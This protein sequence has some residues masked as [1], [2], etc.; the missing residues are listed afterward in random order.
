MQRGLELDAMLTP[1]E[2]MVSSLSASRLSLQN[3]IKEVRKSKEKEARKRVDQATSD[4]RKAVSI[5]STA[6]AAVAA[7]ARADAAAG[8]T[9]NG[10]GRGAQAPSES[11][12][13]FELNMKDEI[14]I[15]V[16]AGCQPLGSQ[17]FRRVESQYGER[18]YIVTG[19]SDMMNC[20]GTVEAAFL[21][22]FLAKCPKDTEGYGKRG[23]SQYPP[24]AGQFM[25]AVKA[26]QALV[27]VGEYVNEKD[28]PEL[29]TWVDNVRM[30]A[31][32]P[33]MKFIGPDFAESGAAR[34]QVAGSKQLIC[35][36][37]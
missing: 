32:H 16:I 36:C 19:V 1:V 21:A 33:L 18:P 35:V 13:I 15:P 25:A 30:F 24:V 37:A 26:F 10:A 7:G 31:Y 14:E 2:Y 27:P 20:S 3:A 17:P 5:S 6:A 8:G 12:N 34:F 29:I 28:V 4:A 22:R 11:Y 23:R 9:G